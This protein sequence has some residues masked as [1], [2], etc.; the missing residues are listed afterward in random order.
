MLKTNEK[1]ICCIIAA[2][3]L[4][5]GMCLE[6]SE[7]DSSFLC[8]SLKQADAA[9]HSVDYLAQNTDSCTSEMIGKNNSMTALR[10][11]L[12]RN[13]IRWDRSVMLLAIVGAILQFLLYL[14]SSSKRGYYEILYSYY[15]WC[16]FRRFT[17]TVSN[18][19]N[20]GNSESK[21]LS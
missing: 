18:R 17:Y 12:G 11:D 19:R 14:R 6:L 10:G 21:N 4:F 2:I 9:F 3:L 13:G 1:I 20:S 15:F 5:A 16:C 7:A 8:T